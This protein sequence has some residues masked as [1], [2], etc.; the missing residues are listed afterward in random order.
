MDNKKLPQIGIIGAGF[1]GSAVASGFSL[2][3]HLKIYDKYLP[4]MDSMEEVANQDFIFVCVPTPMRPDGTQN[5]GILREALG[6]F[7]ACKPSS[8]FPNVIIKSTVMPGTTRAMATTFKYP[9]F[10]MNPEFLTERT[11][12]L[13]FINTSRIIIGGERDEVVDD[14]RMLYRSRFPATP[15]F[16]TTWEGAELVQ[17]MAN[18][19]F[20]TKVSFLNEFY[21]ICQHLGLDYNAVR[22]MWLADGRIGNSHTDVPGHDGDRGFGGKCFPKDLSAICRWTQDVIG[23]PLEVCEAAQAVN[24]RI[25]KKKNWIIED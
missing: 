13:D 18:A 22:D 3:A 6:E 21:D 17:Y 25:R 19:F 4:G 11:A 24:N 8:Y 7:F 10:L 12:R 20:A 5:L 2:H 1:V 23:R 16:H 15:I 14:L 9:Y